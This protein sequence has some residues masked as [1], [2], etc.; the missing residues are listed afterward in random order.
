M[1]HINKRGFEFSFGWIFAVMFGAAIIFLATYLAFSIVTQERKTTDAGLTKGFDTLLYPIGTGLESNKVTL[2]RFPVETKITFQCDAGGDFGQQIIKTSASSSLGTKYTAD[3]VSVKSKD[4][5][6]F[7]EPVIEGEDFL[8]FVKPLNLPFK[9]GD[10]VYIMP[11][12]TRYC[13]VMPSGSNI[14]KELESLR[15]DNLHFNKSIYFADFD[16]CPEDALKVCFNT[17]ETKGCH[18]SVIGNKIIKEG[19]EVYFDEGQ[20]GNALVLAAIFSDPNYYECQLKRLNKRASELAKLYADK[21]KLSAGQCGFEIGL[22]LES[23]ANLT[24]SFSSSNKSLEQVLSLSKQ[25]GGSN[26]QIKCPLF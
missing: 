14:R 18:V 17:A 5:Y 16:A 25:L 13:F 10:L 20:T 11:V 26:G 22:E 23:Y 15:K 9:I 2:I 3:Q 1:R 4:K 8:T 7:S 6:I 12:E 24:R 21:Q 19:K